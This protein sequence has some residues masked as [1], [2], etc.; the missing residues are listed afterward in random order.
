M[1]TRLIRSLALVTLTLVFGCA[2]GGTK[3]IQVWKDPMYGSVLDNVLVIGVA[4]TDTRRRVFE[5]EMSRVFRENGVRATPSFQLVPET[6]K[7]DKESIKAAIQ[8]K[9]FEAVLVTRLLS[10]DEKV[11]YVEGRTYVVDHWGSS[12]HHSYYPYYS[13]SFEIVHEPGYTIETTIVRLETNVYDVASESLVWA[14]VSETFNPD[15]MNEVSRTFGLEVLR[16]LVNQ[17]LVREDD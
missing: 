16:D 15:A 4:K 1:P 14:A 5:T 13:R 9:G 10:I 12:Y 6:D 2:T 7:I 3:L 8:G 17:G 11:E